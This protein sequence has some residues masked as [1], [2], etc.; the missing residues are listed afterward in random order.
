M[1][2]IIKSESSFSLDRFETYK[3]NWDTRDDNE[4]LKSADSSGKFIAKTMRAVF[5]PLLASH[6][7]T[8]FMDKL[9]EKYAMH[10]NEH[11]SIE[12]TDYFNIV[13]SLTRKM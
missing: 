2:E 3:V 7:G 8:T 4:I 13:I 5:E 9:F 11:L 12:K 1:E 6:F 10:V